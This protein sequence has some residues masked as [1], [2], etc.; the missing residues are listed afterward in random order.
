MRRIELAGRRALLSPSLDELAV[1]IKLHY[2]RGGVAAMS[3][4][5]EDIAVWSG[6]H[7]R[8]LIERILAVAGNTGFS[9]REK[10]LALVAELNHDMTLARG[11]W[12]ICAAGRDAV[13]HPNVSF[14]VYV[15]AVR[16]NEHASAE[17]F[18]QVPVF[19]KLENHWNG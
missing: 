10:D 17:A 8:R 1:L 9:K 11:L 15:Y 16:K 18:D 2:T 13:G 12:I 7:I 3:I 4:S 14:F 6:N 19:V 5:D